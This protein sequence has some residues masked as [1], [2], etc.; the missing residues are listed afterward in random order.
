MKPNINDYLRHGLFLNLY[1]LFKYLP[2]PVGDILRYLIVKIFIKHIGKVRIYEGTTFWYP[3]R[4]KIGD[5]VT[6]NEW[7]YLNGYGN[8]TIADGV[9][10]GERTSIITS[11]HNF[12]R[13]D[14]PIYQQEI[15]GAPVIIEKNVW[16]GCHVVILKGV[17]VGEGA[18]IAAG[19]VVTKDVAPFSIVAG[20]PAVKIKNR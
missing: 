2:S 15:I 18:I 12:D 14:I 3:E 5:N 7:V 10:I 4:I 1:G 11:D 13:K 16:I 20:V 9:R 17:R 19:A 8:L 6:L